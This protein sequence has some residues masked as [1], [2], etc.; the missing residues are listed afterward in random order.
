MNVD[1]DFDVIIV[2]GG[3]SGLVTAFKII[4]KTSQLSIRIF[5]ASNRIGGQ[6][7]STRSHHEL[8]ARWIDCGQYQVN[9]LCKQFSIELVRRSVVIENENFKRNWEIDNGIFACLARFE[10]NKFIQKLDLI[11]ENLRFFLTSF[12]SNLLY[13]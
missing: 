7:L 8:G 4:Q 2:G 11:S 9:E 1:I 6:I 5:E 10:L 13:Y 12:Y 3:L